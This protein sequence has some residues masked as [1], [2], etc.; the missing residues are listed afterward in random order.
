M[1][2][3]SKDESIAAVQYSEAL[4]IAPVLFAVLLAQC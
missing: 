3:V 4:S 1:K 2:A